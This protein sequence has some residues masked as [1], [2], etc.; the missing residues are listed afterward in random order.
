M[1][2]KKRV[3]PTADFF[4]KT[5]YKTIEYPY[6]DEDGEEITL[7]FKI[8]NVS[9]TQLISEGKIGNAL[10]KAVNKAFTGERKGKD[11]EN[12]EL[13]GKDLQKLIKLMEDFCK[14]AM[15]EPKYDDVKEYLTMDMMQ[16]IFSGTTEEVQKL[17]TFREESTNT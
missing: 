16:A 9:V 17:E 1:A 15:V 10:V 8:R 5:A 6:V 2:K 13:E 14:A 4:E 12:I 11:G 7:A 3:V